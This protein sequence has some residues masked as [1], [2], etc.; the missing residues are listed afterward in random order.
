MLVQKRLLVACLVFTLIGFCL[1]QS[2]VEAKHAQLELIADAEKTGTILVGVYFQLEP[3]W[4][5]Y[6][7]NPGDSGQ[8]PSFRWTLPAGATAGEVQWPRP[9]RLQT[10]PAIIDYGYRHEVLLML[11]VHFSGS[12]QNNSKLKLSVEAK[13][14]ICRE[15]CLPDHAHLSLSLPAGPENPRTAQLFAKAKA[16]LPHAWP[17]QWKTTVASHKDDLLLTI[18]TG[19]PLTGVEFFPL[20]PGQVD[21]AA[22]QRLTTMP[23]GAKIALKKS[24]L[25]LTPVAELRG[26]LVVGK[27]AYQFRAPVLTPHS[28]LK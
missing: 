8:P 1:A 27:T 17:K 23:N 28:G 9:E 2:Q 4:H 21:N 3:G 24:D 18:L 13:W 11:P 16:L 22:R 25:L 5:I 7:T 14:L 19:H 12:Q 20:D 26:V 6:W 15:V 10:S